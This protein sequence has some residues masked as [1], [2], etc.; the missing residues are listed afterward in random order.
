MLV[1]HFKLNDTHIYLT[2]VPISAEI[3]DPAWMHLIKLSGEHKAKKVG[4]GSRTLHKA[5]K[6]YLF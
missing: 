4:N 3:V 6:K 1:Q 2:K 5:R